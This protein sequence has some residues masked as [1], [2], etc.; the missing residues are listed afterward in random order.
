MIKKEEFAAKLIVI[1]DDN[2]ED[3]MSDDESM[4][5]VVLSVEQFINNIGPIEVGSVGKAHI[6]LHIKG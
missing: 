3:N 1:D 5:L 4:S 6:R 2:S